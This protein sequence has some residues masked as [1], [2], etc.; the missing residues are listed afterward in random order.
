MSAHAGDALV[1]K[2]TLFGRV[3]RSAGAEVGPGR[4]QDAVQALDAVDLRSR[5]E[6]YWALR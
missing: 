4:L 6:V 5:D 3:L 1:R 2:L